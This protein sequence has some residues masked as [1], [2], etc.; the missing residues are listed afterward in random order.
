MNLERDRTLGDLATAVAGR[1]LGAAG[2]GRVAV[3]CEQPAVLFE[4]VERRWG[5]LRRAKQAERN[6][7][8]DVR[9]VT[10]LTK[11][12]VTMQITGFTTRPDVI[13]SDVVFCT[14][15][16]FLANY[17]VGAKVLF[18]TIPTTDEG[19]RLLSSRLPGGTLVVCFG[20]QL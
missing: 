13:E 2:R 8:E 17:G 18:L 7:A 14:H 16:E 1:L 6:R 15:A 9:D 11:V 12:I 4:A 3:V 10:R 20:G 5:R 19:L